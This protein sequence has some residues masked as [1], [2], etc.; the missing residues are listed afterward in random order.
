M[1]EIDEGELTRYRCHV[2]H[3]YT[4]ELMALALD[5]NLSRALGSAL[6]AL[7]ERRALARKLQRQ[8]E[9]GG[10]NAA[11]ASWAL[12]AQEHEGQVI[13]ESIRRADEISARFAKP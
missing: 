5:E 13:R 8:A 2:G 11:A 1:W 12:K 3:A 4:A 10:R 7:D 9:E 6:R